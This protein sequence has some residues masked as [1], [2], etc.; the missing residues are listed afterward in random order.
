M[1]A[2]AGAR[3]LDLFAGSGALGI[4]ALS[5]GAAAATF[6][7]ADGGAAKTVRANLEATGLQGEVVRLDALAF[8][9]GAGHFDL[10]FADPPYDFDG[11]D[12]VL[13]ALD[14]DLV[15]LESGREI[16]LGE[17]WDVLRCRRY[18][19]TVVTVAAAAS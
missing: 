7:D 18:G 1:D 15:V 2:L 9:A 4:E 5:R 19:G 17:R 12:D 3:V 13:S 6:V 16:E 8:L 11:W 14:A 10:A